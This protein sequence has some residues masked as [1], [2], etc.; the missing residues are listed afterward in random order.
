MEMDNCTPPETTGYWSTPNVWPGYQQPFI[1]PKLYVFSVGSP[2]DTPQERDEM[3]HKLRAEIDA[4]KER[5]DMIVIVP[6][7]LG[8]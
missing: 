2:D 3:A 8:V 5:G 4:A 1:A 6:F 7:N